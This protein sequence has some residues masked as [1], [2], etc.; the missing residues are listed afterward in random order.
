MKKNNLEKTAKQFILYLVVG[1]IATVAEWV[2]FYL[3]DSK[4]SLHYVP[5][6][7]IAFILS[8]FVN[9]VCGKILL[10]HEKKNLWKE[11]TQIYFTS[12]AG[13]LMN[14]LIMWVAF[15]NLH[16]NKM[17]SKIIA[18]GIVFFWNFFIRKLVIYE[19]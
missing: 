17:L 12:I 15:D 4:F 19:V 14:L 18:T 8:T 16:I 9:W 1:G 10:F 7:S 2:V 11:L 5:A 3:L 13:L 6:V